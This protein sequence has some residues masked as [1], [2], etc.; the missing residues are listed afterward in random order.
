MNLMPY[1]DLQS[2]GQIRHGALETASFDEHLI[3][4][5]PAAVTIA[6]L[7]GD[8]VIAESDLA[9]ALL[10]CA[11]PRI[12]ERLSRRWPAR[13]DFMAFLARFSQSGRV[14]C[15][16]VRLQ[17]NDG[18]QFWCSVSARMIK[19]ANA[20]H[21]L[22]HMQDLSEQ[23]AARAEIS[24]QR[25]ALHDAEKLSAIGQLMGGIS[26]ELNNPLSILTGQ[27]LMLKE[28]AQDEATAKRADRILNASERCSRIVRS[29]LDLARG[30]PIKPA[31]TNLN[32]IVVEATEA[33]IDMLRGAN[34]EMV[35]DLPKTTPQVTVDADQIRQVVINLIMNAAQAIIGQTGPRRISIVTRQDPATAATI[36][37]VSDTGTG[38]PA[39]ISSRVFDPLFTTKAP[40][41]GTGLGLALCR[42]I[43]EAHAGCIRLEATSARGST[44]VLTFGRQED[45]S[46]SRPTLRVDRRDRNGLSVLVVDDRSRN[47]GTVADILSAEGHGLDLVESTFVG[48]ELLR[49]NRYDAIFCRAGIGDLGVAGCLRAINEARSG[50]VDSVV[51]VLG[52]K[53]DCATLDLLDQLERPY[54]QEPFERRDI[55]DI[56]EL[57]WMRR[58]A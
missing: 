25:D 54:L 19:V 47:G 30:T 10:G 42:Q 28:K 41:G 17:R 36:V 55:L 37:K 49:R 21:I 23:I 5:F 38:V 14:D 15:A 16:E 20:P 7:E 3:R 4:D 24:R 13:R 32:E 52:A 48:V 39:E 56:L 12:G 9:T 46:Q 35:L 26:H 34:I 11:T 51:F 1:V 22:L 31:P 58:A 29:F 2:S 45:A 27:A 33:T 50:A 43:M 57:L 44:F 6:T 8:R 53:A 40:D 18:T